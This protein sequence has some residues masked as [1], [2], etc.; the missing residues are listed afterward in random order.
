MNSSRMSAVVLSFVYLFLPMIFAAPS[1]VDSFK[2]SPP[3]Y[4]ADPLGDYIS[5]M[6]GPEQVDLEEII[7]L[8]TKE[9]ISFGLNEEEESE[10]ITITKTVN[11]LKVA[12]TTMPVE[13][14]E[15]SSDY[16]WRSAPCAGCSSNHQGIDFVP[17]YGEPVLAI[18]DGMVIDMG[19]NGGYGNFIM[20]KHLVGNTEGEIDEWI[21]LYAHLKT[22]SFVEGLKIGSVVKT[23]E[24][25]AAV[26]NTGMSTGAH[27]HF[28]LKIN[29]ENVDPLPLLGTYEVVVVTEEDYE[30]MMF[31]GET[32]K[33]VE[34]EVLYE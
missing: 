33:V 4:S 10:S 34:T 16:G 19:S 6:G 20:L 24:Q 2:N 5:G 27:L 29:G 8:D 30:D 14:P 22:D 11:Y 21:T 32:F 18:T 13:N 26:G 25:L 28:E 23:G 15:V 7:I 3:A 12:N 31:V 17:G 1:E 9:N